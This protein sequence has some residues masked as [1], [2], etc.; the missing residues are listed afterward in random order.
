MVLPPSIARKRVLSSPRPLGHRWVYSVDPIVSCTA[1]LPAPT[2]GD[3]SPVPEPVPRQR[4]TPVAGG[5]CAGLPSL[6]ERLDPSERVSRAARHSS[7]LSRARWCWVQPVTA[8]GIGANSRS[9]SVNVDRDQP[10][11]MT[12][13]LT[14]AGNPPEPTPL[15]RPLAGEH[16]SAR[17]ADVR[18]YL[19][20]QEA[21][22]DFPVVD[23]L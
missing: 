3:A 12:R 4:R 14:P 21:I 1:S 13:A 5:A 8:T 17:S 9:A 20:P 10:L 7:R 2:V 11:A 6:R 16:M 18:D 22:G 19:E 23:A 15:P